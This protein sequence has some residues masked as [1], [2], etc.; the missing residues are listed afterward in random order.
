MHV[1]WAIEGHT[2]ED[3]LEARRLYSILDKARSARQIGW[4]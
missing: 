2:Q 4:T 3:H 1:G